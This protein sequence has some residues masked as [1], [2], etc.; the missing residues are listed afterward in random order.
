MKTSGIIHSYL[1]NLAFELEFSKHLGGEHHC[2][3]VN[4]ASS[5]LFAIFKSLQ[6]KNGE[7]ILA[8]MNWPGS[9]WFFELLGLK[10]ILVDINLETFTIDPL[11][12]QTK[13]NDKTVA[14][15]A[16]DMFG[17]PCD[18]KHLR[19][20]ADN[21]SVPLIGDCAQSFGSYY[22]QKQSGCIA[23]VAVV[24]FGAGKIFNLGEG[25][26][27]YTSNKSHFSK[28]LKEFGHPDIQR[29][30]LG[31]IQNTIVGNIRMNPIAAEEGYSRFSSVVETIKTKVENKLILAK[32]KKSQSQPNFHKQLLQINQS[33]G[34]SFQN[35]IPLEYLLLPHEMKKFKNLNSLYC[36]YRIINN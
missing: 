22:E 5:G 14:I 8:A 13:I 1:Q 26:M 35:P 15:L 25:G 31:K 7:V 36:H 27:I 30:H 28:I 33:F 6:I 19:S 2:L 16:T 17:Y 10:P 24:S 20:I 23:D 4:S 11:E 3:S 9:I 12:V 34:K 21:A 29:I 32:D 18:W